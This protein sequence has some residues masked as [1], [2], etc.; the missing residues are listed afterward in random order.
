MLLNNPLDRVL[1]QVP[2]IRILRFLIGSQ[3]HLNGREIAKSIGFSHVKTHAALKDLAKQGVVNVRSVGRSLM[4]W[5][6][7]EHF[8]VKEILRPAFEKE[9]EIFYLIPRIIINKSKSPKPLSMILY[10]SFAKKDALPDS[11]IDILTIYPKQKSK[12][13]I[14]KEL[15]EAEKKITSLYGNHLA[16]ISLKVNEFINK[17]RKKDRFIKEVVE[18]GRVIYGK[19]ISELIHY[20]FQ[21][22]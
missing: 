22:D 14:P 13:L 6:N 20:G 3:A 5:I 16:A 11:D 18:T 9:A 19:T 4:Y 21:K 2:R 8:L 12:S 10:G 17:Y 7:E 1:G 15:A